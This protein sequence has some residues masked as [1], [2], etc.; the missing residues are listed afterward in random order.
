MTVWRARSACCVLE[1]WPAFRGGR[2]HQ[3]PL[4]AVYPT[5]AIEQL[6]VLLIHSSTTVVLATASTDMMRSIFHTPGAGITI[7]SHCHSQNHA[8]PQI[9][10]SRSRSAAVDHHWPRSRRFCNGHGH[11]MASS[12]LVPERWWYDKSDDDQSAT[13]AHC[14]QYRDS[15]RNRVA[16]TVVGTCRHLQA[17]ANRGI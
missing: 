10:P 14:H 12:R 9:S 11:G 4:S 6:R 1:T 17:T 7:K 2:I 15:A 16:T 5:Y 8:F 3:Q 13:T